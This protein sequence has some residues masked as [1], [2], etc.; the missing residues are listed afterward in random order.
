MTLLMFLEEHVYTSGKQ[1]EIFYKDGMDIS[2]KSFIPI[3]TQLTDLCLK[4]PC[5]KVL[6]I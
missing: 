5:S 4:I 2:R 1:K 3:L 6:P